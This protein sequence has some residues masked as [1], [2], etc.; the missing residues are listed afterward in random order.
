VCSG[1]QRQPPTSRRFSTTLIFKESPCG[2]AVEEAL[3]YSRL[4]LTYTILY[5]VL[6]AVAYSDIPLN[7]KGDLL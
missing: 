3:E 6:L 4:G 7:K 5:L 2:G 1:A